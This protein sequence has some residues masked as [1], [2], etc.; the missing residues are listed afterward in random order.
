[1]VVLPGA[2]HIGPEIALWIGPPILVIGILTWMTMT[3]LASSRKIHPDR[4]CDQSPHW[5][6]VEGGAYHYWPGMYSHSSPD[7]QFPKDL[8]PAPERPGRQPPP[9]NLDGT[10]AEEPKPREPMAEKPGA[11]APGAGE[12]K[13]PARHGPRTPS[14]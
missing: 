4:R 3:I 7:M 10:L 11:E 6:P 2:V 12:P 13:A 5:G 14:A 9:L 8:Y 1:M